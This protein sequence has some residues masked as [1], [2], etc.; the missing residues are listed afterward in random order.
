[1]ECGP[2]LNNG[3]IKGEDGFTG[4]FSDEEDLVPW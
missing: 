2:S 3:P 4:T 1:M